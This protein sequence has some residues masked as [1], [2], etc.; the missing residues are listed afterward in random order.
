MRATSAAAAP[1]NSRIIGGAGT[2]AGPPELLPPQSRRQP[3]WLLDPCPPFELQP[4]ELLQWPLDEDDVE[5]ELDEL[6]EELLDDEVLEL[7][8]VEDETSPLDDEVDVEL[9]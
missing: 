8:E 2:G 7:V 5:D 4:L 3:P 9:I 6:V 1:P